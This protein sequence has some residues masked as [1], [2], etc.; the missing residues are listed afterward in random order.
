MPISPITTAWDVLSNLPHNEAQSQLVWAGQVLHRGDRLM[1][2]GVRDGSVLHVVY[3][4]HLYFDLVTSNAEKIDRG[5]GVRVAAPSR[6]EWGWCTALLPRGITEMSVEIGA[7]GLQ[8]ANVT[9]Y[10]VGVLPERD[11]DVGGRGNALGDQGVGLILSS[12]SSWSGSVKVR[13][14]ASGRPWGIRVFQPGDILT[15]ELA[16]AGTTVRFACGDTWSHPFKVPFTSPVRLGV[17]L[18]CETDARCAV[19]HV[20]CC[21]RPRGLA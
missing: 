11:F 7:T 12:Y 20:T 13:G 5:A 9:D 19:R 14:A 17:S 8:S 16:N 21:S 1:S 6:N 2:A 15:V 10:F 4:K 3:I 18:Y